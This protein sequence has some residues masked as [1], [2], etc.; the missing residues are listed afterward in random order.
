MCL[1]LTAHRT[2][3]QAGDDLRQDEFC[4]LMGALMQRI[5]ETA[6]LPARL[7]SYR[8]VATGH[9]C[10]LIEVVPRYGKALCPIVHTHTHTHTH[11]QTH[12]HTQSIRHFSLTPTAPFSKLY[13]AV[14]N[15]GLCGRRSQT[16]SHHR[17]AG[18][19]QTG[20][21]DVAGAGR[22]LHTVTRG[23]VCV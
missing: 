9:K 16:T 8:V 6:K 1:L 12:T 23:F 5:W 15:S 22:E 21:S 10:G 18:T 17:L 20:V 19:Q 14:E 4:L 11:A 2:V 3:R 13:I 7:L